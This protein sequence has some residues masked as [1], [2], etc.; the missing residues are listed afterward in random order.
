[1]V[2]ARDATSRWGPDRA[3]QD[4]ARGAPPEAPLHGITGGENN[5]GPFDAVYHPLRRPTVTRRF[6]Y[7]YIRQR[8]LWLFASR[9]SDAA[10]QPVRNRQ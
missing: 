10:A 4:H 9:L 1:M 7:V 3:D 2:L 8:V 5:F 6:A